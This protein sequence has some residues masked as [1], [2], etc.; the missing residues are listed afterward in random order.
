MSETIL[1]AQTGPG[2][3]A[4]I[5]R[6]LTLTI[7]GERY[8]I[9]IMDVTEI[10]RFRPPTLVPMTAPHIRG[11]T[12]LRGRVMP[13]IDLCIPFGRG[14]TEPGLHGAIVVVQHR[15]RARESRS[16]GIIVDGINKV[17]HV[18]D[19]DVQPA[20]QASRSHGNCRLVRG[21]A[22]HDGMFVLLLDA[23]EILA[24]NDLPEEDGRGRR[25]GPHDPAG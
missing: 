14:L 3:P 12:N 17:M 4:A 10:V 16:V 15:D 18:S 22:N 9:D 20:Q 7:K 1:S 13:V 25:S 23:V 6:Y 5:T 11:V 2:A 8:A 21:L 24:L 19:D